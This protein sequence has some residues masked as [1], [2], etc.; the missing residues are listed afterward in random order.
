M[1]SAHNFLLFS[2]LFFSALLLFGLD[3]SPTPL[4]RNV[5]KNNMNETTLGDIPF[6][7]RGF[8]RSCCDVYPNVFGKHEGG[9]FEAG[10][11]TDSKYFFKKPIVSGDIVYIVTSDF[12]KF[13]D[14][15]V[16]LNKVN[17]IDLIL[18]L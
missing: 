8:A 18:S 5:L 15:F 16:K 6:W 3:I 11:V 2:F 12:P 17:M 14:V 1:S 9:F 4:Q 10:K 7:S 13:L